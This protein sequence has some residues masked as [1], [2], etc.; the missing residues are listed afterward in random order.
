M[1]HIPTVVRVLVG[2]LFIITG[3]NGFFHFLPMPPMTG[4]SAT[5]MGGFAAARY[6]FP[7]IF[8]TQ[9]VGGVLLLVGRFVP[10]ALAL[11]VPVIVNIFLFHLAL[12]PPAP[13][14]FF[15]LFAEIYLAW[16]YR[17]A[18]RPML[19]LNA[20]PTVASAAA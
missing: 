4:P 8:G 13:V 10:L 7:L 15:L 9:L 19:D 11:L 16:S 17:D 12:T 18:F 3:L 5:V 2:L 20:K 6:L 1:R 14:A